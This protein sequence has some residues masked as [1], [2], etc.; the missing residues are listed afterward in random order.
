[1][2]FMV[3]K[4]TC[5]SVLFL[6]L[7]CCSIGCSRG[8]QRPPTYKV[9]GVVVMDNSPVT[10]A[11]VSFL[12]NNKQ[13]SANGFTDS[14][15]RYE[16][17]SFTRGDGAMEG[18]YR[19]TIVKYQGVDSGAP[20]EKKAVSSED[21]EGDDYVPSG[22]GGPRDTGPKSILPKEFADQENTP[23]EA[24]VEPVGDNVMNFDISGQ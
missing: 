9:T 5:L 3:S 20:E 2:R 11:I 14:S 15:G 10:D 16:L 6:V 13:Q 4:Q 19:V 8:P 1:M 12:P 23:L 24:M 17:T 22:V 7:F 21:Q 18:S